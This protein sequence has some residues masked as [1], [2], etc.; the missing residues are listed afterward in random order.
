MPLTVGD[1]PIRPLTAEEVMRM[2]ETGILGEDDRVELLGGVLTEVS[3]KSAEHGVVIAR[4]VRWLV[5][6]DPTERYLVQTEHP[7]LVPD[8]TSLPE[9]DVA[10]LPSGGD[11]R[12]HPPGA[13]L[14][15]EVTVS[16]L[17]V[18]SEV[19]P[20]LFAAAKV[21]EMW[22]VEPRRRRVIRFTEPGPGGYAARDVLSDG[23]LAPRAVDVPPLSLSELFADL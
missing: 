6:S 14:V 2:V 23:R 22:V 11:V 3:P 21:P 13:L 8:R 12:R 4:L 19:K 5:A 16:S 17:R 18:D 15:V 10:V 20:P 9:P 7:V 1:R